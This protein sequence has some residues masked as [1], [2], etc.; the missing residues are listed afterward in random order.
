MLET[1]CGHTQVVDSNILA[2]GSATYSRNVES[3]GTEELD[4]GQTTVEETDT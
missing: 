2:S 3:D 1:C 4:G